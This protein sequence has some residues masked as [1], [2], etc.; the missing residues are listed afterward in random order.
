MRKLYILTL[1]ENCIWHANLQFEMDKHN[2]VS[3]RQW[4]FQ[5]EDPCNLPFELLIIGHH[6]RELSVM[7]HHEQAQV[8]YTML[9]D[10]GGR[11]LLPVIEV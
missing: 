7:G 8:E 10:Q 6:N 1:R 4:H 9:A 2:Q 5:H 3:P 11:W